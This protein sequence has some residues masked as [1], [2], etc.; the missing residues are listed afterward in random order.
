MVEQLERVFCGRTLSKPLIYLV[1][2]QMITALIA[3]LLGK[4]TALCIAPDEMGRYNLAYVAMSFFHSLL[5]VPTISAFKAHLIGGNPAPTISFYGCCL[6][7]IYG[8]ALTITGILSWMLNQPSLLLI[9]LVGV[10]QGFYALG[11]EYLTINALHRVYS[12]VQIAYI[13]FNLLVLCI[14]TVGFNWRTAT[15]LWW[16]ALLLNASFAL[17]TLSY[18]KPTICEFQL[19]IKPPAAGITNDQIKRYRKY[20]TP[21]LNLALWSA[22]ANY[23][24]RYLIK[25][26][27]TDA[28]VGQYAVAYSVGSKVVLLVAPLITYLTPAIYQMSAQEASD[29]LIDAELM[30]YLRYYGLIAG[31][32]CLTFLLFHKLIGQLLL[33]EA[34]AQAYLVGPVIAFAYLFLTCTHILEIKWYANSQ[35][36]LIV[37]HNS[38][39]ALSAIGLNIVL[40]PRLGI[41]GAALATVGGF[42]CQL[43]L[44]FYLFKNTA[45]YKLKR[46]T[47]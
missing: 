24:D 12:R 1:S 20:A 7:A 18:T 3:L 13:T 35:T 8:I 43:G 31:C 34:Y 46:A 44:C 45:H 26:F 30:R 15:D 47:V 5:I 39:G 37:W 36:R 42:A 14:F 2:S 29:D 4:A 19:S 11:K 10:G 27:M 33:A 6:L 32:C 9:G 38:I 22:L 25:F 16:I 17:I 40:I 21:L 23:A 41:I 28:D